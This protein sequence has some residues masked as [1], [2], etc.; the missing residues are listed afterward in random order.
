MNDYKTILSTKGYFV[1]NIVGTS[2]FPML[3]QGKDTV[4]L[5]PIDRTIKKYDVV[6]FQRDNGKYVLHRVLKANNGA[7]IICGDNQYK[8]EY[9]IKDHN[10]IAIMAGFYRKERYVSI[11]NFWY[12]LYSRL[13]SL[14]RPFVFLKFM[15]I[16]FFR[17]RGTK[18]EWFNYWI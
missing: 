5:K 9:T 6:L 7:Y 8:K 11:D 1:T 3:R 15:F 18:N 14:F 17:K 4:L 12:K 10:M 16:K 13:V 2:M